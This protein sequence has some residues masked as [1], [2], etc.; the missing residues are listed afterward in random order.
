[1]PSLR[2]VEELEEGGWDWEIGGA[3]GVLVS[4][5]LG[6]RIDANESYL[7]FPIECLKSLRSAVDPRVWPFDFQEVGAGR[8]F[9]PIANK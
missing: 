1:M 6:A 8:E 5:A 9:E 3:C 4:K 2:H 7:E